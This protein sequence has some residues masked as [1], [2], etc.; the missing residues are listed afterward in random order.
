MIPTKV[1]IEPQKIAG[2][3]PSLSVNTPE[4]KDPNMLPKK[5]DEVLSPVVAGVSLK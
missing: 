5:T 3:R 4:I 2:R 1:I